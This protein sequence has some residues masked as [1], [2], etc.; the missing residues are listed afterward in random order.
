MASSGRELGLLWGGSAS[1]GDGAPLPLATE[2]HLLWR[3]NSAS[4]GDGAPPPL[5]RQ[6]PPRLEESA[7]CVAD[8]P[9][10]PYV[11]LGCCAAANRPP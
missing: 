7:V 4:S 9:P 5:A 8:D 11:R 1:P 3:R 10:P 2:L 6:L